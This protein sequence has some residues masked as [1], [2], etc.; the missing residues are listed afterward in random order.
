MVKAPKYRSLNHFTG[1]V[2]PMPV[3]NDRKARN[4]EAARR[5]V[6]T[7]DRNADCDPDDYIRG[8]DR[9]ME[10]QLN[11]VADWISDALATHWGTGSWTASHNLRQLTLQQ[12]SMVLIAWGAS[13]FLIEQF[14]QDLLNR[15]HSSSFKAGSR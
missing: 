13:P 8:G 5:A 9:L 14:A 1:K 4:L 6:E 7:L 3:K 10:D 15:V 2:Q 11:V 12:I